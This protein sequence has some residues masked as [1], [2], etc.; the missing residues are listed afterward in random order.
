[1]LQINTSVENEDFQVEFSF[2]QHL[3]TTNQFRIE[4]QTRQ[5]VG[6]YVLFIDV[7]TN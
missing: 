2:K 5:S 4:F 7:F 1:M 6:N 3:I